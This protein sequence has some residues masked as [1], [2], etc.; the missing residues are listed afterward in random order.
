MRLL[1]L[2]C[3]MPPA[4][5]AANDPPIDIWPDTAPGETTRNTGQ[6]LP[7]REHEIPPVTRVVNITQPTMT[8]HRPQQP[9]GTGLLILPGG[10][11]GKVVP[12][13]EGT[14]AA[15]WLNS[16]GITAFVL[17]YRTLGDGESR[18]G[19]EEPLQDAKRALS[20]IRARA[21]Q[22]ELRTDRI[23]LLGF[24]AGGQVAARLLCGPDE[25]SWRRQDAIDDVSHR[26]DFAI[27]VYPWNLWDRD[28]QAL[29]D[30]LVVPPDCPP[31]FLVHTHDD[32]SSSLGAVMI[33]AGL[34]QYGIPAELHVYGNGGHGYGLRPVAGSQISGWP[35]HA[36]HWLLRRGMTDVASADPFAPE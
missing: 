11:F 19:W 8:V 9:N 4:L 12:D 24:S 10:G 22:W 33:Y 17:S 23:G 21:D 6:Q 29:V 34:K 18:P 27:L 14:E 15:D 5:A 25:K 2:A 7:F 32:R 13:K 20:L 16:L 3:L 26:P 1:L 35:D 28:Q 36:A 31:A 30:G